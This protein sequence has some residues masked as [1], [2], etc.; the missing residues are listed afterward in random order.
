MLDSSTTDHFMAV[1][2]QVK[3][4]VPTT[5]K[6]NV[7]IPDGT[8]MHSTHECEIDWPRLPLS[9]RQAR[10]ISTLAQQSLLLVVK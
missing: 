8:S 6:I 2:A 9:A 5:S 7:I 3:N 1:Q 10:I 4:T